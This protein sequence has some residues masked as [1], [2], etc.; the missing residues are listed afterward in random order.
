MATEV[1]DPELLAK[2]NGASAT[3][4]TPAAPGAAV[5]DPALLARLGGDSVDAS[6]RVSHDNAHAPKDPL[7]F[8]DQVHLAQA[9]NF[10]EKELYFQNKYGK[11]AVKREW[12]S[13]GK[14]ALLVTTTD[15]KLYRIGEAGFVAQLTADSPKLISMGAGAATG[16]EIGALGGPLDPITVP[17]GAVIGAGLGAV[18]GKGATEAQKGIEGNYKKTPGQLVGAL[19]DASAEGMEGQMG[20]MMAGKLTSKILSSR[21]PSF[22]TGA[23]EETRD[24][25]QKAWAAG[26]RP[27]YASMAPDAMKLRRIEVDADKLTGP[28]KAQDERNMAY[29]LSTLKDTLKQSGMPPAYV[30]KIAEEAQ[31]PF[32]A[33]SH[34]AIGQ[35]IKVSVQAHIDAITA[36]IDKT[37]KVADSHIDA[38]LSAVTKII[39]SSTHAGLGEDVATAIKS[40]KK[41]FSDASSKLYSR[42]DGL[43]GDQKVVPT[44]GISAV[45]KSIIKDMPPSEVARITKE[46]AQLAGRPLSAEDAILLKEFGVE[47]DPGQT[48][49]SFAQAQNLRS[50]LRAKG[51]PQSLTHG[52]KEGTHLRLADA[53]DDAI[54]EAAS[55]PVAAPAVKALDVA[56]KFYK[57]GIGKFKDAQIK[58]LV[59]GLSTGM[60]PDPE[61]IVNV[62]AGPG[63]SSRIA[64]IHKMV[65]DDVWR[66]VQSVHMQQYLDRF[67]S[68]GETGAPVLDGIKILKSLREGDATKSFAAIQGEGSVA[69]LREIGAMLA[70]RQGKLAPDALTKGTVKDALLAMK[71]HQAR[72]D[73]FMSR[74]A[75]SILADP[76]KTGEEAYQYLVRPGADGEARTM[77]AA[78]LFGINSPQMKGLQQAAIEE[79]ARN[80]NINAI[81]KSGNRALENALSQFTKNQQ[82]LLF[83]NG[84]ADDLR[85]LSKVIQFMFPFKSGE[86]SDTAMA[87]MHAGAVLEKPLRKRLYIQAVAAVTRFVALHPS[88]ARWIVTGRDEGTPWIRRTAGLIQKMAQVGTAE[89]ARP[90]QPP[91]PPPTPMPAPATVQ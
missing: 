3:D 91:G 5:T 12:G 62:I 17:A 70:S 58:Q 9:D 41:D 87:G 81:D 21:L 56:D 29:V 13:D 20:G 36:A 24:M 37:A 88:V 50:I 8:T 66:R 42:I 71:A 84:A 63:N 25:T 90:A 76:K 46:A 33:A 89:A 38:Q 23:T 31:N 72:L 59:K 65:G 16:A 27:P 52:I 57:D 78:K 45:A 43:I 61:A 22:M 73:E 44:E 83:P 18:F 26:A 51:K 7:P 79:M 48:K 77:A 67:T 15:G 68:T 4:D 86:A 6:G 39:D 19:D 74:N 11:S 49:M 53:V 47:L 2:L 40:A 69:D 34:E 28:N 30:D 10:D 60:P 82:D 54:H 35:D 14:P 64:T 85:Q 55:D 80:A 32:A 1:T 75:L